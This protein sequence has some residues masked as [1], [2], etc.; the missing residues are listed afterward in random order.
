MD[1]CKD[2]HFYVCE[3]NI[4]EDRPKIYYS[5]SDEKFPYSRK[6]RSTFVFHHD[7]DYEFLGKENREVILQVDDILDMFDKLKFL[8][9]EVIKTRNKF[10]IME[11]EFNELKTHLEYMPDGIKFEEVKKD[12]EEMRSSIQN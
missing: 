7:T 11:K 6:Y 10:N 3:G 8:N 12:F 1:D 4:I 9:E 2:E 5:S